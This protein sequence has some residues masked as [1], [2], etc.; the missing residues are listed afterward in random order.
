MHD[1]KS[2]PPE[3]LAQVLIENDLYNSF[4][5]EFSEVDFVKHKFPL[6]QDTWRHFVK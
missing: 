6:G 4:L 1:L 5:E 2:Y 3:E